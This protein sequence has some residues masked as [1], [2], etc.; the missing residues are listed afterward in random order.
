MTSNNTPTK[1]NSF[2]TTHLLKLDNIVTPSTDVECRFLGVETSYFIS[3]QG[4][5]AINESEVNSFM[6]CS[7]E[8]IDWFPVIFDSGASLF[9]IPCKDDVLREIQVP[10]KPL[11]L[12]G[13]ALG[14][15]ING[16]V[17]VEWSFNTAT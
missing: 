2:S 15:P 17:T 13:L 8:M 6:N 9:I 16:N 4:Y 3:P 7:G 5:N 1:P 14:L 12:G 10:D 11:R